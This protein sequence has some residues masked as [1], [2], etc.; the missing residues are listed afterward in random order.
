MSP[1]RD[2]PPLPPSCSD[3]RK[4]YWQ[5][6]LSPPLLLDR[7][8]PAPD[9]QF[10]YLVA[11]AET[12]PFTEEHLATFTQLGETKDYP[13]YYF[14]RDPFWIECHLPLPGYARRNFAV[15]GF[16]TDY[17]EH[18]L[19]LHGETIEYKYD[20]SVGDWQ[21]IF[22]TEQGEV[23]LR[24]RKA[25]RFLDEWR[26]DYGKPCSMKACPE[27]SDPFYMP[28]V[29]CEACHSEE[30]YWKQ[31]AEAFLVAALV[32]MPT[33]LREKKEPAEEKRQV[34]SPEPHAKKEVRKPSV[35]VVHPL[36][37]DRYRRAH[38]GRGAD[39]MARAEKYLWMYSAWLMVEALRLGGDDNPLHI[40][41]NPLYIELEQERI[42]YGQHVAAFLFFP[43]QD[44]DWI[45][46]V[47]GGDGRTVWSLIYEKQTWTLP[48]DYGCPESQ[49]STQETE[50]GR[51]YH[52]CSLCQQRL[53]HYT[54]W[55]AIALR[56][57][58]GDFREQVELQEPEFV[59]ETSTGEMPEDQGNQQRN[60]QLYRYRVIRY[61]DACRYTGKSPQTKRGSW[62]TGRPLAESEYDVNLDALLYVVIFP[63]EH[64]RNYRHE[65]FVR[66]RGKTQRIEPKPR[67]QPMT[68]AKFR[69]L[70]QRQPI[71]HVLA[72]R[73]ATGEYQ[74]IERQ[75]D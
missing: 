26:V 33:L 4:R 27:A 65:R 21:L 9:I 46:S 58:A 43:K 23:F 10:G 45:L 41:A 35:V 28:G 66:M 19:L 38:Q 51:V 12:V 2:M 7:Y 37:I 3:L 63:K 39:M 34:S 74:G 71:T 44:Q 70:K 25:I 50:H 53:G 49:C 6:I 57:L 32:G 24:L 69:Q 30:R 40:P 8:R 14:L 59:L 11:Y 47:L 64:D 18:P 42:L 61:F 68:I 17:D 29:R 31:V 15:L 60:P 73:Y 55:I 72:S 13:P 1:V 52:L 5:Q 75:T 54:S 36:L 48:Q 22:I 67:L 56:M 16:R 20:T 62:M